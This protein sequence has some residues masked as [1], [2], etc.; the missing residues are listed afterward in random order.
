MNGKR[1]TKIYIIK[2]KKFKMDNTQLTKKAF[3]AALIITPPLGL[4]QPI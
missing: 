2:L 4:I 1:D 3:H